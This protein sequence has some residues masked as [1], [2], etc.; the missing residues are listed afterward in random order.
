MMRDDMPEISEK[1]FEQ[2]A[3]S[4]RARVWMETAARATA[5]AAPRLLTAL[6][7]GAEDAVLD[8]CCG[9]GILAG[10]ALAIG[11]RTTGIDYA[12]AMIAKARERTPDVEFRLG[13]A[14]ALDVREETFDVVA[15]NFALQ[16]IADPDRA[17]K[18]ALRALKPG[19]R[20]GWTHWLA[21]QQNDVARACFEA[22]ALLAP[23]SAEM[24]RETDLYRLAEAEAA[25]TAMRR[26]GF[27]D[28]RTETVRVD[29]AAPRG[30]VAETAVA[31]L[32]RTPLALDRQSIP[33]LEEIYEQIE[34]ALIGANNAETIQLTAPAL[35]C[36]GVKPLRPAARG[37]KFGFVK[38]ALEGGRASERQ[39]AAPRSRRRFLRS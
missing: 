4:A 10:A 6:E 32:S 15:C 29:F 36:I 7:V 9:P 34:R 13:D 33:I 26:A 11:A 31:M 2:D 1:N 21:P 30:A 28:V 22:L 17:M 5:P 18:E 14:Q 38:K 19:G 25:E 20:F 16:Q 35:L 3:W 37:G 23:D 24:F 27:R 12:P 8:L 39:Q